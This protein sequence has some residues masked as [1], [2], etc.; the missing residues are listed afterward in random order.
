MFPD[1]S[2][3]E[4][5]HYPESLDSS[6]EETTKEPECSLENLVTLA[7]WA[8]WAKKRMNYLKDRMTFFQEANKKVI[9]ERRQTEEVLEQCKI[10]MRRGLTEV[11]R[12][13][14][15]Y[16]SAEKLIKANEERENQLALRQ[17]RVI[18]PGSLVNVATMYAPRVVKVEEARI[19]RGGRVRYLVSYWS[20]QGVRCESLIDSS[21]VEEI[22]TDYLPLPSDTSSESEKI[23]ERGSIASHFPVVTD[24]EN[25]D[26]GKYRG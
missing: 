5:S 4:N 18:E 20:D 2:F 19:G 1:N 23:R 15:N 12:L 22:I 24:N 21:E 16:E 11:A 10:E 7:K 17:R 6:K 8:V 13:K 9:S 14:Q 25:T 3:F 26:L